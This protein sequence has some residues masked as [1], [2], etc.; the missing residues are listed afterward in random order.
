MLV[1]NKLT[2]AKRIDDLEIRHLVEKRIHDLSFEPYDLDVLGYFLVVE[3]SDSTEEIDAQL[4]FS[5]LGNRWNG[6]YFGEADFTPS[7]EVVE[8]HFGFFDMVFVI[9]DDGYGVEVIVPKSSGI[10]SN[11]LAMC[12]QYAIPAQEPI[13]P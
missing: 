12:R 1:I 9:S 11:L 2:D 4:G 8:E 10:D 6:T 13:K 5:F 7:F 3:S